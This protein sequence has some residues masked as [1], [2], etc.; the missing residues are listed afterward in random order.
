MKIYSTVFRGISRFAR[1]YVRNWY[2]ESRYPA[3]PGIFHRPG[4]SRRS[5]RT[6]GHGGCER[7]WR[8]WPGLRRPRERERERFPEPG[9]R[10]I[11]VDTRVRLFG[12]GWWPRAGFD[13]TTDS[14]DAAES[15]VPL[16]L[17][18]SRTYPTLPIR[19]FAERR[20]PGVLPRDLL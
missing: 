15:L 5:R 19:M 11:I 4:T 1:D 3:F 9:R 17:A 10:F 8:R 14:R 7:E 2:E 6:A 12:G 18:G 13:V 20:W 16:L